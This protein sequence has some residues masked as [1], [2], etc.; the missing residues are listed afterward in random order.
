MPQNADF[1]RLVSLA[2]HDLRTPLATAGGFARTLT[3]LG[4]LEEPAARYVG[5]IE[6]ATAQ[7]AELLDEL[8]LVARIEGG[9]YEPTIAESDSLDLARGAAT[10]LGEDRVGVEGEGGAVRVDP[11]PTERAVSALAQCAL[12]H[13]G[14]ERVT[15]T[16]HGPELTIAPITPASAPVVLGQDLRDLGAAVATRLISALGGSIELD[17]ETLRVRLPS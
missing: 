5:I 13:G 11:G 17:G 2:C 3:R 15:V 8:A 6:E 10:R 9:R 14:L 12:R 1:A 16:A 7:M 4:E